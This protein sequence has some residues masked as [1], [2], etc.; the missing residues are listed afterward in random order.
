LLDR[1]FLRRRELSAA[2]KSLL[3]QFFGYQRYMEI[4]W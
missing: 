4:R 2:E 3:I 1:P